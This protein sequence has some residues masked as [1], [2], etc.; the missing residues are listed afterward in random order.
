MPVG[1][2]PTPCPANPTTPIVAA[3]KSPLTTIPNSSIVASQHPLTHQI[4]SQR[5]PQ[6]SPGPP[7]SVCPTSPAHSGTNSPAV[8]SLVSSCGG[9]VRS[10]SFGTADSYSL[11]ATPDSVI[12]ATTNSSSLFG[13]KSPPSP[14]LATAKT[15]KSKSKKKNP[16]VSNCSVPSTTTT[17]A[18]TTPPIVGVCTGVNCQLEVCHPAQEAQ[19]VVE[20]GDDHKAMIIRIE[21]STNDKKIT[22]TNNNHKPVNGQI[23]SDTSPDNSRQS[24]ADLSQPQPNSIVV[25]LLNKKGTEKKPSLNLNGLIKPSTINLHSPPNNVV[26]VAQQHQSSCQNHV[27]TASQVVKNNLDNNSRTQSPSPD[28]ETMKL[29]IQQQQENIQQLLMTPPQ[30]ESSSTTMDE[31]SILDSVNA[32]LY[33]TMAERRLNEQLGIETTT[34]TTIK[35]KPKRKSKKKN[36]DVDVDGV[37]LKIEDIHFEDIVE[38]PKK[39]PKKK[40]SKRKNAV[41]AAIDDPTAVPTDDGAPPAKKKKKTKKQRELENHLANNVDTTANQSLVH[42]Q[43]FRQPLPPVLNSTVPQTNQLQQPLQYVATIQQQ[44]GTTAQ[45]VVRVPPPAAGKLKYTCEW[46]GCEK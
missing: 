39:M 42:Q 41:L 23:D 45:I 38:T 25:S 2:T 5:P 12:S 32:V 37:E 4:L 33:E 20:T 16:L 13:P 17:T 21:N 6:F 29:N 15:K 43:S 18:T 14:L 30:N 44:G 35:K 36:A 8:R 27:T 46:E 19:A 9:R 22:A 40:P 31:D 26:V 24:S 7:S 1:S 34:P 28:M 11:P 3:S 10:D